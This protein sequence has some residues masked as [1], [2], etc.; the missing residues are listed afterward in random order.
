MTCVE[1]ILEWLDQYAPFRYAEQ[2]DRC[3]L[4]V[5]D[6]AAAVD[7]V[8]VALDPNSGTIAE[9][10]ARRCDCLV[11]HHPLILHPLKALRE[12]EF[13]GGLVLRVVRQGL[14]VIAAHTSLDAAK[15][16]TNDILAGLLS[17]GSLEP[18]H[19]SPQWQGEPLYGGMGRIGRLEQAM[20]LE[21]LVEKV[22]GL[23]GTRDVRVVGDPAGQVHKVALCTGSGAG[24][25]ES[26]IAA[27][28]DVYLTGDVKYHEAQRAAEGGL[29]LI[30][31]GHFASERIVVAPL[32]DYLRSKA[33]RRS[34][35]LRVFTAKAECDPFWVYRSLAVGKG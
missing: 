6:P 8:L 20:R 17:L 4:Q 29:S 35:D 12:D 1:D 23:L 34:P 9:A 11:T 30:D 31:V 26:V 28:C 13:P 16:G 21:Q 33:E 27:G 10:E 3:G 19:V 2:W 18:L 22:T 32:A 5:G 14:H 24:L 7:R 25:M 15:G